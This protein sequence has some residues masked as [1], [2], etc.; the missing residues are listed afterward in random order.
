M[1]Q[2]WEIALP[3]QFNPVCSHLLLLLSCRMLIVFIEGNKSTGQKMGDTA[4]G[5]S[6]DASNQGKGVS[7]LR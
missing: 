3:E 5:G 7:T 6:D 1:P 2:E 4:R